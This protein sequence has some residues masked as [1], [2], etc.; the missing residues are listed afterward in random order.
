MVSV[1]VVPVALDAEPLELARAAPS[2]QC[3]GEGRGIP[4]GTRR[5]APRPCSCPR[6]GTAPRSSIRS[7]G[8]GSPSPAHSWNHSR[9]SA[10]TALTTSFSDLVQRVP[11]VDVAIGIGRAV[12]QHVF[13]P[14]GGILAQA[15]VEPHLLPAGHDLRLLLGQARA[16]REVGLRQVERLGIVERVGHGLAIAWTRGMTPRRAGSYELEMRIARKDCPGPSGGSGRPEGRAG[17]SDREGAK[18]RARCHAAPCNRRTARKKGVLAGGCGRSSRECQV[19]C[20][21]G[22]RLEK[23]RFRRTSHPYSMVRYGS[24]V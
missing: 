6:R 5:P 9:A 7:A 11:D 15:P 17:N 23:T 22:T 10:W 24:Y 21:C 19:G 16:H 20:R 14:A 13:R 4:G 18:D 3:F 1:G 12:V 2:I 8:R